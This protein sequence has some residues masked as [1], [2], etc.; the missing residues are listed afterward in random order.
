MLRLLGLAATF[1]PASAQQTIQ[2]G[3]SNGW[4]VQ[5]YTDIGAAVGAT[6]DHPSP[7][8]TYM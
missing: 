7:A 1:L 5:A 2:V 4:S 6:G 8:S 3:G